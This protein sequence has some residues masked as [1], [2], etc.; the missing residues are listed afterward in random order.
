MICI[1]IKVEMHVFISRN[2]LLQSIFVGVQLL[3]N[4]FTAVKMISL[5]GRTHKAAI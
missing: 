4:I 1:C 2:N 5:A 3:K